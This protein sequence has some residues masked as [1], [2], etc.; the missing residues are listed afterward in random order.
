M[1]GSNEGSDTKQNP[2]LIATLKK[3]LSQNLFKFCN[4]AC[5]TDENSKRYKTKSTRMIILVSN[6]PYGNEATALKFC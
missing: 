2:E 4:N 3:S 1:E 6:I 5:K